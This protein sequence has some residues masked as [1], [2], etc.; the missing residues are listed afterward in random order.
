M[1]GPLLRLGLRVADA[2]ARSLPSGVAYAL[3]DLGGRAWYRLSPGRRPLV[4][5]NLRRVAAATGRPTSD[6]A[7]R[8]LV[9]RAYIN[10]AR[11][12]LEMLR[13]PHYRDQEIPQIIHVEEWDRWAPVL[14]EGLVI[15]LPHLGNFEPYGHFVVGQGLRAVAPVEE[16]DPP[17]LFDFLRAR[18][19]SGKVEVV[20]LSRS[21]RPMLAA[22]RGGDLVALI[23]DRDLA[24][25]GVPVTMFGHAATLPA[26]PAMLALRTKR[27]L[28]MARVLRTAP[29]RFSVRAELVEAPRSGQVEQDVTALTAA[30][31]ARFEAAIA[32]APEQWFAAFQPYWTDQRTGEAEG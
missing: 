16:T 31:A 21:Y 25:D 13:A 2:V 29:D 15:A 6:R 14:R 19:A 23:A 27:P 3:A 17:E 12:W 5:E 30:L 28:M 8:R 20:P 10:H 32:E 7:M 1:R 4:T 9:Q 22:L 11:Y 18:R 24:G 26:G